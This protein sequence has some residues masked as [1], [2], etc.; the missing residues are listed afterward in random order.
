MSAI[1]ADGQ[2]APLRADRPLTRAKAVR[3]ARAYVGAYN[4][5]DLGAMLALQDEE[6]I[7]HPSRLF[8]NGPHRGHAG[9]RE[10]WAAMVAS[11]RWYEVVISDIRLVGPDRVAIIGEIRE[12]GEKL[13][14]WGV[15]VR[16]RDGLIIES[17]SYL[18]DEELLEELGL[19]G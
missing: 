17:R 10:W 6:V 12:H 7:S 4:D 9:V 16:V 19:L 8:R 1:E 18:S 2:R 13:S 3:L 11:G 14:P 15:V 5:R